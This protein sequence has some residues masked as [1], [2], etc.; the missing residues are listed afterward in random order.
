MTTS[1]RRFLKQG[2]TA[3]GAAGLC[4]AFGN[5]NVL[6]A[7]AAHASFP[8]GDYK[9]LVCIFLHGGNDSFN[10]IVPYSATEYAAYRT[11]RNVLV[12]DGGIAFDQATIQAQSLSALAAAGGL[13]GGVPSD[14]GSYGMHP[15][16]TELRQL[17]N[18]G[19]AAIVANVGTLLYPTSQAAY[20]AGTIA[21]PPQL[22]SHL[23][24]STYWQTSR[25]DDANA[26]GWGGRIADRLHS[27]NSGPVPM[28]VS[29]SSNN[30]FQRGDIVDSY[31]VS[32]EGVEKMS[33]LGDGPESWVIPPN[34]DGIAAYQ[35]LLAGNTQEHVFERA[36]ADRSRNAVANYEFVDAALNGATPLSTAFP[37]TSLGQQLRMAARLIQVRAA[38]GMSR[39]VFY[40]S[41]G[42]YDSHNNQVDD[43]QSNLGQLSQA[44][45]A[46]HDATVELAIDQ[47][48][49]AFTASDFGRSLG[50]NVDGTDH[51]WGGHHFVVGGAVRGQRFYGA[52][53]SLRDTANPDD[54]G[55]G[56]IIPTT[57]VDQYAATLA[58]WFGVSNTE[59]ADIFPSLAH[60]NSANLGFLG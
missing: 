46:F 43:Q 29:L 10:S 22:F 15:A 20:Q 57:A 44:L 24:Q 19:H 34:D 58:K 31:S 48:V 7:A 1:R 41:A 17:F 30:L 50:V 55:F 39:Q 21:V 11:S 2:L 36:F 16:L 5:L 3:F 37:A 45:K 59:I 26:N 28:C 9:A 18:A 56:Q 40:V 42:N 53:P 38:L 23:D 12:S 33:Y 13:P 52:M 4:G 25:P 51:G 27:A 54:T 47:S 8:P 14:G 60:F 6:A 35:A 32:P 49:T